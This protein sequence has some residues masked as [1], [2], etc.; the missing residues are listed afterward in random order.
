MR[1]PKSTIGV[2]G[3][4]GLMLIALA[5]SGSARQTVKPSSDKIPITTADP[6]A[7]KLYVQARDLAEK[8]RATDARKLYEQAV[9]RDPKFALAYVGLANTSGTNR[10]FVEATEKAVALAGNVSEGERHIILALDAGLKGDP[11]AVLN[12][13]SDLVRLFPNDE[14]AHNLLGNVYFGRQEYEKAVS[15]YTKATA[16]APSYS[17]P[18]NQLGYAYR[19]LEKYDEAERTFRKY[20]ELIPG[21]PNPHDSYAELLMKIGRFDESIKAYEKALSIDPNFVA[22]HVGIG[23]NY[24]CMSQPD[25]ARAAFSKIAAVARTTGERRLARFW[26]A[27][28]YVHEGATDKALEEIKANSALSA[29]EQDGGTISGDLNLMGDILREAGRLDE[30]QARYAEAVAAIEKARVPDE[31]KEATR[32]NHLFEQGRLAAAKHDLATARAR[33]GEYAAKVAVRKAP[34]EVRQQHELAGLIALAEKRY[35]AAA[36]ELAQAGQQDPRIL[37]LTA[38]AFRGAGDSAQATAL[39]G[40]A[41]KFNGLNFSWAYVRKAAQKGAGT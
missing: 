11:S 23:N 25:Q 4:I 39:A 14:R 31:V 12:H 28:A 37:Y 18:Y 24:L 27:A 34:F 35:D 8:L 38:V 17:Q 33:A 2:G 7:R 26:T 30:A 9:A 22:S 19:F 36:K 13:N 16:I 41:A 29:A 21:D 32:R 15:H 20:T 5:T 40:K 3:G 1:S 10:E 6:E